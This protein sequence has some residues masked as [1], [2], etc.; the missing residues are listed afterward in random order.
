MAEVFD[1]GH[2]CIG[3]GIK[4]DIDPWGSPGNEGSRFLDGLK[5]GRKKK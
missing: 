2:I 4:G 3:K 1:R 5:E